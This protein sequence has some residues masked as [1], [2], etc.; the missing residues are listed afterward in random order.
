M[1]A[2]IHAEGEIPVIPLPDVISRY[3]NGS[4]DL[5]VDQGGEDLVVERN[6]PIIESE[7][8]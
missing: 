5:S 3:K 7:T 2:L 1:P 4:W 8:D 6:V